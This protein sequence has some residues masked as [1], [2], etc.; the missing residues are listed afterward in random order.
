M[1]A[2]LILVAELLMAN[3][4]VSVCLSMKGNLHEGLVVYQRI[5][6]I[7]HHVDLIHNVQ[8]WIMAFQNVLVFRDI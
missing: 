3:P 4:C 1:H 6:V 8:F 5:H 2:A 7:L